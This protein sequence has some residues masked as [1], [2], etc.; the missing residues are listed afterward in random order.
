ME[1]LSNTTHKDRVA[2]FNSKLEALSEHHDIPKASLRN[3]KRELRDLTS[4]T[5][6]LDLGNTNSR[7]TPRTV[8][9]CYSMS[10]CTNTISSN[11]KFM[12]AVCRFLAQMSPRSSV[13]VVVVSVTVVKIPNYIVVCDVFVPQ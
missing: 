13:S 4:P 7:S 12:R 5:I 8:R 2:E 3:L 11:D 9:I 1:K 10:L 6:R